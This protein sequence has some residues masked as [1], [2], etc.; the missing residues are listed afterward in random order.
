MLKVTAI[1][2]AFNK[3]IVAIRASFDTAL[4]KTRFANL[5]MPRGLPFALSH[6]A[7]IRSSSKF[8]GANLAF[9]FLNA[10]DS[11]LYVINSFT[12]F[13]EVS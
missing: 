8:G 12:S 6:I 13:I 11:N 7:L 1:G 5:K 3:S 9:W 4:L 2:Y 10:G